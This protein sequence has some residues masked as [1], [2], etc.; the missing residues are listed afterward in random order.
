MAGVEG[1]ITSL[2]YPA[3]YYHNLDY[4]IHVRGPNQSRVVFQFDSINIEPQAD[5]LYDYVSVV[6]MKG[7]ENRT[8]TVCGYR[9]NNLEEWVHV[10]IFIQNHHHTQIP[11]FYFCPKYFRF[12]LLSP[13][14]FLIYCVHVCV[15]VCVQLRFCDRYKRSVRAFPFRLFGVEFGVSSH[16]ERDRYVGMFVTELDRFRGPRCQPELSKIHTAQLGLH[17]CNYGTR[18]DENENLNKISPSSPP[19]PR[20]R[21][22]NKFKEQNNTT[23]LFL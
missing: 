23:I 22:Q 21:T 19:P 20:R 3:N 9:G 13:T 18:W 17:H 16:V 15:C 10:P 4:W 5:C 2:N 12:N 1:V 7:S 14:N 11:S 6:E 8:M